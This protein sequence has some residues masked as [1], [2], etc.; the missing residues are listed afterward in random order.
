MRSVARLVYVLRAGG[1][2]DFRYEPVYRLTRGDTV[3]E[4]DLYR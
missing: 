4:V 1:N 2:G 3:V